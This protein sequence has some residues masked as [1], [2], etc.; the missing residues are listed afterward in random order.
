[1][2]ISRWSDAISGI[3]GGC[4]HLFD[5]ALHVEVSFGNLVKLALKDFLESADRL[6]NGH[7]LPLGACEDFG[8]MER[9]AQEA[10]DLTGAIYGEFIVGR[11]LVH[12]KDRDDVLEILVA[13]ENLLDAAGH[14]VV[15][16]A[17]DLRGKCLGG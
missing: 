15:L 11:K 4:E 7:I 1:V 10:L 6:R 12:T 2:T 9:L 3:L 16:L 14:R 8:N 17:N 5:A 13:L